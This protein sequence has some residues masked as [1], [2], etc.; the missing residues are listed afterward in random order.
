MTSSSTE[1]TIFLGDFQQAATADLFQMHIQVFRLTRISFSTKYWGKE[2]VPMLLKCDF[3]VAEH[4]SPTCQLCERS[5]P[6]WPC[7]W[8]GG[9]RRKA[10]LESWAKMGHKILNHR[11][12]NVLPEPYLNQSSLRVIT[13]L[14]PWWWG[15]VSVRTK[16]QAWQSPEG[17]V[18]VHAE[19]CQPSSATWSAPLQQS[20]GSQQAKVSMVSCKELLWGVL[21][22]ITTVHTIALK[23][24][25]QDL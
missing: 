17:W 25:S 20:P 24:V 11:H 18:P 10:E 9:V 4:K 12:W 3:G 5:I 13:D 19:Q 14:L 6:T 21:P 7:E 1:N 8:P 15:V 22:E 2:T 16:E 23:F